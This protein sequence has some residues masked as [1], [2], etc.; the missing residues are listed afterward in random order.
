M[1]FSLALISLCL[2]SLAA[3]EVLS[4][5]PGQK[6]LEDKGGEVPGENPLT[7]CKADHSDDILELDH[8]NLDPNPPKAC[9]FSCAASHKFYNLTRRIV[10]R[11]SRSRRLVH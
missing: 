8:V 11:N 7:Y 10:D 3:S 1:K 4:F 9:V 6:V 2:S 5:F